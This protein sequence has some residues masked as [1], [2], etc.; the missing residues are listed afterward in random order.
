MRILI[1]EDNADISASI[2]DFLEGRGHIMDAAPDGV[3]GLHL[4]V[5]NDYDVIILDL[6]PPETT[7]LNRF[8]TREFLAEVRRILAPGGVLL[9]P[10]PAAPNL[11]SPTHRRLHSILWVTLRES[12]EH[13][14]IFPGSSSGSG[15]LSRRPRRTAG[16]SVSA[17]TTSGGS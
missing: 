12:F 4:A 10:L 14:L 5:S 6:P 7:Q 17:C 13:V 16:T 8:Y 3:T 2:Y 1:I 11:R 9:L 15:S